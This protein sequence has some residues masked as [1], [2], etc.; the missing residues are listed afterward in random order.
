MET[1]SI[2]IPCRSEGDLLRLH[3]MGL[4]HHLDGDVVRLHRPDQPRA[5]FDLAIVEHDGSGRDLD[6]G[7][8]A[9]AR[10]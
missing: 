5:P 4:V 9:D 3:P 7:A 1:S 2:G 8:A 6:G 10:A